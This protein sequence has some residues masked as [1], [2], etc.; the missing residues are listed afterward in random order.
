M[1]GGGGKGAPALRTSTL[2]HVMKLLCSEELAAAIIGKGG[3]TI[4]SM[5]M[6]C[7]AK[8]TLTDHGDFY[9]GTD[10]RV[11]TAQANSEDALHELSRQVFVKVLQLASSCAP[12]AVGTEMELKIKT[13]VPRAAA[14]GIIGKGGNMI[15]QL[16]D[17]SGAKISIGDP[18][19]SGPNADQLVTISGSLE[20]L[21]L[22]IVEVNRQIR[23]L[24][25]EPWFASW[26]LTTGTSS[27]ANVPRINT[28]GGGGASGHHRPAHEPPSYTT[29]G[30]DV[31]MRVA[32]GLPP[33]VMEDSRGFALSC[34][35]PNSLVG[36]LIGRGGLGTKQVQMETG[37]KIEFRD[38]P[39]D[40]ENRSL[41]ITGPLPNTCAAYMLM[42]QR[43]LESE[44]RSSR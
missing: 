36:G 12:D 40:T 18:N 42:M 2:P 23:M 39:G 19:G 25:E 41:N 17:S 13:L 29:P 34:V 7:E 10:C 32:Q 37:A 15:K 24:N 9:P 11:L 30:L 8:V 14:G 26:A 3:T 6:S 35:V 44:G 1:K 27:V 16:R 38:L 28:G 22:V 43:Y 4:A 33:Y 31:M 5:R 20:A 21:G